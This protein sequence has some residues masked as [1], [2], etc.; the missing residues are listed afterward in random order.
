[1]NQMLMTQKEAFLR[2][3]CIVGACAC[4]VIG[5]VFILQD[6]VYH[7]NLDHIDLLFT[8]MPFLPIFL[9]APRYKNGSIVY[10]FIGFFEM[11]II[12]LNHFI[13]LR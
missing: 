8:A 2:M 4:F 12:V 10:C 9:V 3:A 11:I 7:I 5:V 6:I 13:V 1:M